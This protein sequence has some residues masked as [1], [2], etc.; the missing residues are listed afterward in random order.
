MV[1]LSSTFGAYALA[2][3]DYFCTLR[4]FPEALRV[5]SLE[6]EPA[7]GLVLLWDPL[8]PVVSLFY[9][10][11]LDAAVFLVEPVLFELPD[12]VPDASLLGR[13]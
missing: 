5:L 13:V 2:L 8:E 12:L 6:P 1:F 11:P 10:T 9:L 4:V 3:G 7:L